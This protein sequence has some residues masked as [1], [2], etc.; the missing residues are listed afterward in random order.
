MREIKFR[1]QRFDTKE[2]IHGSLLEDDIIVTKGATDVD[3]DYIGFSDDWSSVIKE[4]VGQYTGLKDKNGTEIYEG[5]IVKFED[6]GEEGYEYKEGFDFTNYASVVF[7]NG[8]WELDNF[9]DD[10]SG[11]LETM[12]SCHEDFISE[13]KTFE[14]IGNIYENSELLE[15]RE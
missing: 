10:N 3:S 8:R 14:V 2:W 11:I 9:L 1:G 13:F 6:V 12:N 4:T 7:E 5:D 15:G